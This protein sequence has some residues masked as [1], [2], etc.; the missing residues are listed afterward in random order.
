MW[1][2]EYYRDYHELHC[3]RLIPYGNPKFDYPFE[4]WDRDTLMVK[5]GFPPTLLKSS[6]FCILKVE[7]GLVLHPINIYTG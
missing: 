6:Y 4:E 7:H 5:Y 1:I 2:P 3:P